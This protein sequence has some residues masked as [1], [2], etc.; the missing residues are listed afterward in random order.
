MLERPVVQEKI[1]ED[2]SQKRDPDVLK[3]EKYSRLFKLIETINTVKSNNPT[4]PLPT[5]DTQR[6]IKKSISNLQNLMKQPQSGGYH[7]RNTKR[8]RH[9]KKGRN[10]RKYN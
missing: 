10:T 2:I 6:I 1:K 7:K 9:S 3:N 5:A 4:I 8:R